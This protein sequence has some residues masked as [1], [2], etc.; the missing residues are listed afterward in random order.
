MVLSA[1]GIWACESAVDGPAP[2]IEA[3]DSGAPAIE[4]G[5]VCRDQLTTEVRIHGRAFSPSP[6]DVPGDP[7]TALPT[8]TLVGRQGLDGA[9]PPAAGAADVR[10]GGEREQINAAKL[11]WQSQQQLTFTV[12]QELVLD[13]TGATGRL[14]AAVFDVRVLN[15]TGNQVEV[16]AQLA[17]IDRPSL[18]EVTPSITCLAQGERTV[19]LD[20][21]SQAVIDGLPA[22]VDIGPASDFAIGEFQ[23]CTDVPHETVPGKLCTAADVPLAQ[24]A[25]PVGFHGITFQNPAP[26]ACHSE[27]DIRLRVVPPPSLTG[28][29]PPLVCTAEGERE[30]I[31]DGADLLDIDGMLPAVTMTAP[32]GTPM[33]ITVR[34]LGGTCEMLETRN[35]EVRTCTEITVVLPQDPALAAPYAPVFELT[36]PGPAGCLATLEDAL[37]ITPPPVIVE[38]VPPAICTG[39]RDRDVEIRGEG[40][41]EVDGTPPA[42][43]M[44]DL[45]VEVISF[46]DCDTL[47]VVGMTVQRCA[48]MTVRVP[49]GELAVA[50]GEAYAQPLIRVENPQPAGCFVV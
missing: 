45:D 16:P 25:L 40:F 47:P 17:A 34:S 6:I 38:A 3:P 12:D 10:Y 31:L 33:A 20:G 44:D 23:D 28:V 48:S 49:Q 8:L 39:E 29:R 19:R 30:V 2:Q 41:L 27:E 46:A 24:D 14:P 36:N 13:D 50:M 26:A 4:P 43:K 11:T 9:T 22:T 15:P 5:Y 18:T 32:D 1:A 7:R 35:H 42:V 37:I 21:A